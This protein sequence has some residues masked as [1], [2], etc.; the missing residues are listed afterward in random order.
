V[1]RRAGQ[2]IY[3]DLAIMTALTLRAVFRLALGQT[4]ELIGPILQ[5][6]GVELAVPDRLRHALTSNK[7]TSSSQQS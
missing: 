2:R 1:Q 4:E 7:R 3:S 6:L 5:L